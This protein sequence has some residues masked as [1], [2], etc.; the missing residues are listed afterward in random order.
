MSAAPHKPP[1][2]HPWRGALRQTVE[3]PIETERACRGCG[4]RQPMSE[5]R[6]AAA[7]SIYRGHTCYGCIRERS[8][9][10]HQ[11]RRERGIAYHRPRWSREKE[12]AA[13]LRRKVAAR[14][15]AGLVVAP[16]HWWTVPT[17]AAEAGLS[18]NKVYRLV[19]AGRLV[20][21][22]D[23]DGRRWRIDPAIVLALRD[24]RAS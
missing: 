10:Y 1:A 16:R 22:R 6:P 2:D 21:L 9:R 15:A 3:R 4:R 12:N 23:S 13:R 20:A 19:W 24:R 7:G 5:F 18:T 11:V 8:R 14:R 17:V